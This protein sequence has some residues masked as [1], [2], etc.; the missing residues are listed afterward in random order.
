MWK[1]WIRTKFL[2][3]AGYV[4]SRRLAWILVCI[5][6]WQSEID[7]GENWPLR[8]HTAV[9]QRIQS[10]T[11]PH[12]NVYL[13]SQSWRCAQL[14]GLCDRIIQQIL[15]CQFFVTVWRWCTS[16][17]LAYEQRLTL[18][19][20]SIGYGLFHRSI[21]CMPISSACMVNACMHSWLVVWYHAVVCII[22]W[23]LKPT[24]CLVSTWQSTVQQLA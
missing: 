10:V 24:S 15:K 4:S 5:P 21:I 3:I 1:L 14:H 9:S 16:L 12:A 17:A 8:S 2:L 6:C 11:Q 13:C 18:E 22:Y 7:T 20:I 23:D 19:T